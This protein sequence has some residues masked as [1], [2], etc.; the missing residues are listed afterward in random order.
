MGR[1]IEVK[2]T[3]D[4]DN[5]SEV[6]G[7]IEMLHGFLPEGYV[8]E[9]RASD[10]KEMEVKDAEE[11][12]APAKKA[13]AKKAAAK[14]TAPVQE[15]D[16]EDDGG[17]ELTINDV[18]ATLAEAIQNGGNKIAIKSKLTKL[19]AKNVTTLDPSKFKEF[20]DF[21]KEL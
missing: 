4:V 19:G 21:L 14:K 15:E 10:V 7:L 20:S 3:V 17:E 18:R 6:Q 1:S 13:P 16:P 12:K 8:F 11:V 9:D 2:F 5:K